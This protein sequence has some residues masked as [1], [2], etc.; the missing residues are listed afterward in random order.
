MVDN[1]FQLTFAYK[2][3]FGNGQITLNIVVLYEYF[4]LY[5]LREYAIYSLR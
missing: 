5:Y 1:G 4:L 3:S 2:C